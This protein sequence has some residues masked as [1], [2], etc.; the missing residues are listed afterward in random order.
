[1]EMDWVSTIT[2]LCD[3]EPVTNGESPYPDTA[4]GGQRVSVHRQGRD[5]ILGLAHSDRDLVAFL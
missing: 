5:E 1:M 4:S 2:Q 3:R